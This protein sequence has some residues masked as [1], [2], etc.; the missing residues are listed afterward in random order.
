MRSM[1]VRPQA[2][3]LI[4]MPAAREIPPPANDNRPARREIRMSPL[5]RRSLV[6]ASLLATA[7]LFLGWAGWLGH[8]AWAMLH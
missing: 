3:A 1:R 8:T 4:R 2:T 6:A 5:V 7:G